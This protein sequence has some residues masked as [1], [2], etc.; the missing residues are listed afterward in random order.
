VL[1]R[2]ELLA[3]AEGREALPMW[4]LAKLRKR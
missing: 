1:D 3:F 4:F 2:F